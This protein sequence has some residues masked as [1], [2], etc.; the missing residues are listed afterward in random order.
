M[1]D[2]KLVKHKDG[3]ACMWTPTN[4]AAPIIVGFTRATN[5]ADLLKFKIKCR[6]REATGSTNREHYP[7]L[8]EK[9]RNAAIDRRTAD[10]AKRLRY[11]DFDNG[12]L[13]GL[14]DIHNDKLIAVV[15]DRKEAKRIAQALNREHIRANAL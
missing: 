1:I 15:F 3:T 10:R 6:R 14:I 13:V 4:G 12:K 2:V 5:E 8:N 9:E 11:I 7:T